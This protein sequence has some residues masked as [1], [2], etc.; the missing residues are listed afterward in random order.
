M[1]K[2]L[3]IF[4]LLLT[5][6]ISNLNATT[7]QLKSA[8]IIECDGVLYGTHGSDNHYHVAEE[9]EKGTYQAKG[10]S[11]GTN[12]TCKTTATNINENK[13]LEKIT[14]TFVNCVDGDTAV[15]KINGQE[16]KF[17]FLAVDTPETVHPTKEVE[18][19]G[20]DA[21][22]YTCNK[23]KNAKVIEIEY[24]D[25]KTDKYGRDLGWI[26]VDGNLLQKELIEI[27]Y[28]EVAYIYGNYKYT[29]LLC[30][31]QARAIENKK[32]IWNDE[33]RK[34]G[35]CSTLRTT[36]ETKTTISL[37]NETQKEKN[38]KDYTLETIAAAI[39]AVLIVIIKGVK[40]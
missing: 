24:E 38:E 40:K 28:A 39:I 36:P 9:T 25:S 23:I 31:S 20:K 2:K 37:N 26:W 15:F 33:T 1:K 35:Y 7:G 6:N 21:S 13:E 29:N 11:L 10:E 27:G 16:K 22:E 8:S 3:L 4:I 5:I 19:Y 14:A 17:R 32:G 34:E 18:E 30:D 12:W